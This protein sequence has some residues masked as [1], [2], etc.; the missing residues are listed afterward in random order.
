MNQS[1]FEM[2]KGVK[3]IW[4]GFDTTFPK[5][6]ELVLTPL[7]QKVA[8][9]QSSSFL[10]IPIFIRKRLIDESTICLIIDN[11]ISDKGIIL[12]SKIIKIVSPKLGA[13]LKFQLPYV[14]EGDN[15]TIEIVKGRIL[16]MPWTKPASTDGVLI[17]EGTDARINSPNMKI[18]LKILQ[19]LYS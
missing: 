5:N 17:I 2:S 4:A 18:K 7:F 3:K 12:Q 6:Y 1:A 10:I 14:S 16:W 19:K 13:S 15:S 8:Q 9:H 11:S